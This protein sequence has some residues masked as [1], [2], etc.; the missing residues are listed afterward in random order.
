MGSTVNEKLASD[1]LLGVKYNKNK[2]I[3]SKKGI[4]KFY[5]KIQVK[6]WKSKKS[7]DLKTE[8]FSWK[9]LFKECP[10][11]DDKGND[12]NNNNI[13]VLGALH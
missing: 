13:M 4:F 12:Y 3:R 7:L 2:N 1:L 5:M 11:S 8:Y 9:L 10:W 6:L